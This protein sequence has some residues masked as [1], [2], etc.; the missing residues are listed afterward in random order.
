MSDL[1]S[2][3]LQLIRQMES[4]APPYYGPLRIIES[5]EMADDVLDWAPCRSVARAMRRM[6]AT[7]SRGRKKRSHPQRCRWIKVPRKAALMFNDTAVMHPEM[8]AAVRA[9]IPERAISGT[10]R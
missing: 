1:L 10:I 8:A 6:S 5:L 3:I 2:N 4:R 9:L 7:S